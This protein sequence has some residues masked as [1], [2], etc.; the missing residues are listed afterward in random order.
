MI[1]LQSQKDGDKS[2]TL[3]LNNRV[4]L[5]FRDESDLASLKS[6]L[7]QQEDSVKEVQF[8]T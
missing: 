7:V 1:D 2:L 4:T 8:F 3:N 5:N 6:Q